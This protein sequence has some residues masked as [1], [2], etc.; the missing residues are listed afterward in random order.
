V[1]CQTISCA[2]PNTNPKFFGTETVG[3]QTVSCADPADS[4]DPDDKQAP[5]NPSHVRSVPDITPSSRSWSPG[6]RNASV[7]LVVFLR[8]HPLSVGLPP[9][10]CHK[11]GWV[12]DPLI[13]APKP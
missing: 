3:C 5:L 7:S 4:D 8:I 11:G 9:E 1:G 13:T 6:S 2:D 12:A 10:G